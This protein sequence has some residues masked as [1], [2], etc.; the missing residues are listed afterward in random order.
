[1]GWASTSYNGVNFV[2]SSNTRHEDWGRDE[3]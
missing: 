2:L 3:G 1:M